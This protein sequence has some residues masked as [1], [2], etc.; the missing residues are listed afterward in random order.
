VYTVGVGLCEMHKR[1]YLLFWAV[2]MTM[3]LYQLSHDNFILDTI[4]PHFPRSVHCNQTLTRTRALVTILTSIS[5]DYTTLVQMLGLSISMH[6]DVDCQ[7]DQILIVPDDVTI[8]QRDLDRF[9]FAGWRVMPLARIPPPASV[10]SH[11]VIHG[12]HLQCFS[13]LHVFNMTQ[14]EAVLF[15]DADTILCGNVMEVFSHHIPRMRDQGVHLGWVYDVTVASMNSSFNSGVMLVR[16]CSHLSAHLLTSMQEIA[17]DPSFADQGFLN[18]VFNTRD[19]VHAESIHRQHYVLPPKFNAM[20]NIPS[21]NQ[22]LWEH[23]KTD[24]RIFHFLWMKPTALF[25]LPRCAYMGTLHFCIMWQ[26]IR[27]RLL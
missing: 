25:M 26:H 2:A 6:S 7:V 9:K 16:P 4:T 27:S 8:A 20:A 11:T 10:N 22:E 15:V 18:V 5:S 23:V 14:Y 21:I 19:P 3:C 13:K 1:V 24:A 12:R 17:F